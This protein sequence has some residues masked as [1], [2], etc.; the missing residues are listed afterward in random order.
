MLM[1]SR[2]LDVAEPEQQ[3]RVKGED[4]LSEASSAAPEFVVSAQGTRR[5]TYGAKWFWLLLPK[6]KEFVVWGRNPVK[7]FFK[8]LL[9][10]QY[11][12]SHLQDTHPIPAQTHTSHRTVEG[13]PEPK[14]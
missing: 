8:L 13:N 14:L 5:A 9:P 7:I 3:I 11:G 4:C 1:V 6:Q 12:E 2:P 10:F